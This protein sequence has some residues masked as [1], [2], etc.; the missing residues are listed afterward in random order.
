MSGQGNSPDSTGGVYYALKG[1]T[2]ATAITGND[3]SSGAAS[4]DTRMVTV[5]NGQLYVS[6]DSKEGSGPARSYIGTL[7]A[8]GSPPTSLANNGGGPTALS[9]FQAKG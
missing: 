2:T 3:T 9:G 5:D 6:V 7:G 4:Q 8:A 1:A